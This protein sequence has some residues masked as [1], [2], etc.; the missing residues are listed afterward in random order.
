MEIVKTI[1]AMN[2]FS[3]LVDKFNWSCEKNQTG[4]LLNISLSKNPDTAP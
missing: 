3:F 2:H 4:L 1:C